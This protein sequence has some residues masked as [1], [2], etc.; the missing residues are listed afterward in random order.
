MENYI[1]IPCKGKDASGNRCDKKVYYTSEITSGTGLTN[2]S[3]LET[4][5]TEIYL[6]C[7]DDHTHKYIISINH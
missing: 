5:E 7:E 4:T 6:T 2:I 1:E 3:E